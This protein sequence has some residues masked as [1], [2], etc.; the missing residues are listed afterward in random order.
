M[1]QFDVA[2]ATLDGPLALAL[3]FPMQAGAVQRQTGQTLGIFGGLGI[4]VTDAQERS[5]L[6]NSGRSWGL[7]L[8]AQGVVGWMTIARA[9][10]TPAVVTLEGEGTKYCSEGAWAV[11]GLGQQRLV[12]KGALERLLGRQ[13]LRGVAEDREH[14]FSR[15]GLQEFLQ[16]AQGDVGSLQQGVEVRLGGLSPRLKQ[17]VRDEGRLDHIR[18]SK[19]DT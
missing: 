1:C 13:R 3:G 19:Y 7:G 4:G 6:L 5:D 14:E 11:V 9:G 15:L 12:A 16:V 17:A 2:L 18:Y 10:W 8:K